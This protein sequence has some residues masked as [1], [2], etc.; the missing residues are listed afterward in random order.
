MGTAAVGE[1]RARLP[2]VKRERV[3][4]GDGI[5]VCQEPLWGAEGEEFLAGDLAYG[6]LIQQRPH[7]EPPVDKHS[8]HGSVA[9]PVVGRAQGVGAICARD[10]RLRTLHQCR[11]VFQ[12]C[13]R[14]VRHVTRQY[15]HDIVTRRCQG[16]LET[17]KW[18]TLRY[19]V[20]YDTHRGTRRRARS[21]DHHEII[22]QESK[23]FELALEHRSPANQEPALVSAAKA[24]RVTASQ[25]GST[26]H[27]PIISRVS[28][29]S[30]LEANR[31]WAT[32][33]V[34]IV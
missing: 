2:V 33:Q 26:Q 21:P 10:H 30:C 32:F 12:E 8:F 7:R 24:A 1:T 20:V 34:V 28:G 16:G 19:P 11:Q 15:D 25:N 3:V 5:H 23:L 31:R 9:G 18:T 4:V 17:A 22:A 29:S 14:Y 27:G 13:G 6:Q